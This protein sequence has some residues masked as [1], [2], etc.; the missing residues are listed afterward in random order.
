[1]D[2]SRKVLDDFVGMAVRGE[3]CFFLHFRECVKI[4]ALPHIDCYVHEEGGWVGGGGGK[5]CGDWLSNLHYQPSHGHNKSMLYLYNHISHWKT[6]HLLGMP[7]I[8]PH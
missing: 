4:G 3:N 5:G 1:M 2:A 8:A 6:L 7:I